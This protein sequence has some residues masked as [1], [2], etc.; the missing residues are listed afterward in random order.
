LN[1]DLDPNSYSRRVAQIGKET[2]E[3][4][5]EATKTIRQQEIESGML[6]NLSVKEIA[7]NVSVTM[8]GMIDDIIEGRY[9][10]AELFKQDRIIYVG[11]IAIILGLAVYIIDIT[12]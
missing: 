9:S 10:F 12:S 6:T 8:V 4:Y 7:N 3:Y 11:I 1:A 2:L 5:T